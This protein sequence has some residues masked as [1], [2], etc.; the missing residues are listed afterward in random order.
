MSATPHRDTPILHGHEPRGHRVRTV[1]YARRDGMLA[2]ALVASDGLD[3]MARRVAQWDPRLRASG[4]R[5]NRLVVHSLTGQPLFSDSVDAGWRCT[6]LGDAGQALQEWDGRGL[7]RRREFDACLRGTAVHEAAVCVER[8]SYG[9]AAGNGSGQ[10]VRHDHPAGTRHFDEHGVQG[11]VLCRREYLLQTLDV[12]DWPAAVFERDA[13]LEREPSI[14]EWRFNAL[15]E[16]VEQQDAAGHRRSISRALDGREKAAAVSLAGGAPQP[17]LVAI[18][19]DAAGRILKESLGNGVDIRHD[20]AN[21]TGWLM[22]LQSTRGQGE[23]LQDLNYQYDAVG[24]VTQIEDLAQPPRYFGNQRLEARNTYRYDSLYQLIEATGWEAVG[25]LGGPGL[26]EFETLPPDPARIGQYT[27]TYQYNEGNNLIEL[28]HVGRQNYPR[29][30]AVAVD[31]NRAL[32]QAGDHPPSE[33][34]FIEGFDANGN[35]R[36]LAPGQRMIWDGRNQLHC[37]EPAIRDGAENDSE[38]YRYDASGQRVRK[39]RRSL[40]KSVTHAAEVRYLPGLE[41]RNDTATGEHLETLVLQVGTASVRVLHWQSGRPSAIANDQVRYNLANHLGSA[42]LELDGSAQ[43]ISHEHYYPFGGTCWWAGRTHVEAGYKTVRYSGQERDASGLYYYGARYYAPWL[44]RWICPDPAEMADGL[45]VWIF[46]HNRAMRFKDRSGMVGEDTV[47]KDFER[48]GGKILA[49][50]LS[51]F[52]PLYRATATTATEMAIGF[53]DK[54]LEVLSTSPFSAGVI[55]VLGE[56]FGADVADDIGSFPGLTA[57]LGQQFAQ[58]RSMLAHMLEPQGDWRFGLAEFKDASVNALS[59][60]SDKAPEKRMSVMWLSRKSLENA[61]VIYTAHSVVHEVTHLALE[62]ADFWFQSSPLRKGKFS[63]GALSQ[64]MTNQFG[65][66]EYMG[67]DTDAM[68]DGD[69]LEYGQLIG[70]SENPGQAAPLLDAKD[71]FQQDLKKRVNIVKRNADSV[72]SL[73]FKLARL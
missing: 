14:S 42:T 32:Q 47:D 62:T 46:V 49:E 17:V 21:D 37:V 63:P 71:V 28:R 41:I 54:A 30:M 36:F 64:F 40:A 34:D 70:G 5:A 60:P 15:G 51:S 61:D 8:L 65:I 6:L 67:P 50:G 45:N 57:D 58:I 72:A 7:V 11:I 29:R 2:V 22:R 43:L 44:Q 55:K 73:A 53:V 26:P 52:P 33:S 1:E 13:L 16:Q 18:D 19:H 3:A 9:D 59:G 56:V 39:V 68:F 10:L 23:V 48:M 38:H 12:V 20:Y 66:V 69:K 25:H 35:Q 27:Q 31:S 24:N 4:Q